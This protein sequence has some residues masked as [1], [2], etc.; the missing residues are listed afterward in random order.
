[1][2]VAFFGGFDPDYPRNLVLREGLDSSG[3]S[4]RMLD[5][6]PRDPGIVRDAKLLSRWAGSLGSVDALMVPAFGHR[7]MP[8]AWALARASGVPVLFDPLVSR[9]DTQVGDLGRVRAGSLAAR[10]LRA[11]D[12][13]A[14]SLADLVLC[15]TWE[16]GDLFS[17]EFGV[18]RAKL[19]RVPVG[20]DRGAFD[21][22][23]RR[24]GERRSGRLEVVYVGGFL[25]LH[26][27]DTIVEA[28]ALLEA[29]HGPRFARVTLIGDGMTAPRAERD[30]A[31]KGLISVRR[32]ARLPYGEALD[33]LAAA[34]VALGIF[35]TTAKAGR[36]VPHK[37]YQSMA[38]GI[39]TI[40]RRSRAVSEFF[41][42]GEHLALI[43]PG[44]PAALARAIE[45]LAA[46]P[47]RSRAMAARGRASAIGQASPEPIGAILADAI[48]RARDRT[49]PRVKR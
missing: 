9:W 18:P 28:A 36:V 22:G 39:P 26:G 38:M 37:V 14:L 34:D 6:P 16:H 19:V 17:S 8:L 43:P 42:D 11:S 10:R 7:D 45:G 40:S 20:A 24:S 5:A 1:M 31:A 27:V 15:D 35:G 13:V 44:D 49:A 2:R 29:R 30:I 32:A 33:A 25:P 47:D 21:R 48:Q 41:R 46:D 23:A 3:I 4:S 12:R